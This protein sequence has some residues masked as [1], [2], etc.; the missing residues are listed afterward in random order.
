MILRDIPFLI[1]FS[2][3]ILRDK[4]VVIDMEPVKIVY[5][6]VR[7]SE[8]ETKRI[9]DFVKNIQPFLP[10]V[11]EELHATFK[12]YGFK[13]TAIFGENGVFP[14]EWVIEKKPVS[15]FVKQIATETESGEGIIQG[16]F[17]EPH[18]NSKEVVEN[19]Y[20]NENPLHLTISLAEGIPAVRTGRIPKEFKQDIHNPHEEDFII[21]GYVDVFM[22]NGKFFS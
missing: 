9:L 10:C 16:L 17:L 7:F 18:P 21:T 19:Y 8:E 4:K 11:K 14:M 3:D 15:F 13:N 1:L 20:Q 2:C 22:K 12:Y 6:C 5:Q